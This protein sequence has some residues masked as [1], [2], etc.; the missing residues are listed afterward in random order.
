MPKQKTHK[1]V[2]KRV[3][4]SKNGKVKRKKGF[5]SHLMSEKSGKRKRH[6]RKSESM[7][8]AFTK[9][10]IKVLFD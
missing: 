9:K 1:G 4:V 8:S 6:L 2:K 5:K 7:S 10:V 3:S